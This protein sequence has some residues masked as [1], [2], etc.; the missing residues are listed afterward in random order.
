MESVTP[1][2]HW[3]CFRCLGSRRSRNNWL[4]K[5]QASDM[6][7]SAF[8]VFWDH[9]NSFAFCTIVE[10][11]ECSF[12]R[13]L[14]PWEAMTRLSHRVSIMVTDD[15]ATYEGRTLRA[16]FVGPTWGPSGADRTQVGPMLA[17]WTLLS[18]T[19]SNIIIYLVLPDY[20]TLSAVRF[21]ARYRSLTY[22]VS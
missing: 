18:G 11:W 10:H 5:T 1:T 17:P 8:Y 7:V 2:S 6:T 9:A 13:H 16:R 20:S 21:N 14:S 22:K 19:I 3:I 12:S 4:I 15:L